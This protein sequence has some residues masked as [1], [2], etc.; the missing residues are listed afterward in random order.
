[1][2]RL[3]KIPGAILTRFYGDGKYSGSSMKANTGVVHSTETLGLPDYNGGATAPT[4]TLVPDWKAKDLK[5]YQHYDV[6]E[7]ARALKNKLGGVET[8]TLNVFQMEIVGTCDPVKHQEWK[9]K[10]HLYMPELPDWAIA[11]IAWL[12]RWLNINAGIPL[13]STTKPWLPYPDSYGSKR[14]QRMS[15]AEW[16][17]FYGWCGHQHVVENDHGD[18][19]KF[20]MDRVLALAS[21]PPA[22]TTPKEK[23]I[24]SIMVYGKF[25]TPDCAGAGGVVEGEAKYKE[26]AFTASLPAVK[27]AITAGSKVIVVGGPAIQELGLTWAAVGKTSIRGNTIVCN[28]KEYTDSII[29]L[30]QAL[31]SI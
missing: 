15:A 22:S 12:V 5:I 16:L 10:P 18:P 8:N 29:L 11:K 19:G 17:S 26:V 21:K 4:V 1:M 25:G 7:S 14:G 31:K 13:K 9:N 30:A 28:G 24:V 23:L 27:R 6:D 2:A 20:P 3:Q